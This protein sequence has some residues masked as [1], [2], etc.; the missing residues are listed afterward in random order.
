MYPVQC[1]KCFPFGP[2]SNNAVAL[3]LN[4][5]CR[6]WWVVCDLN[7][8]KCVTS[9]KSIWKCSHPFLPPYVHTHSSYSF[10]LLQDPIT[11]IHIRC[12]L[13]ISEHLPTAQ[14]FHSLQ[15][16]KAK[17]LTVLIPTPFQKQSSGRPHALV[18]LKEDW[19]KQ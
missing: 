15:M 13:A 14:T 5:S 11:V 12:R 9:Y 6:D 10:D 18:C 2:F 1:T 16:A 3:H 7:S 17:T 19:T 4:S 8:L